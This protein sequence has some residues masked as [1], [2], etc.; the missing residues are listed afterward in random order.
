MTEN[1]S[2]QALRQWAFGQVE[3]DAES[4]AGPRHDG[5]GQKLRSTSP[6]ATARRVFPENGTSGKPVRQ[7]DD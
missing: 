7:P 4:A 6:Q 2:N 1:L 5:K 3:N